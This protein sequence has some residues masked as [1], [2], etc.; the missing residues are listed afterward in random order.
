[1][2]Q[3][4]KVVVIHGPNLNL[5]GTREP[6]IYGTTTLAEINEMIQ[7]AA[8]SLGWDADCF[9]SNHEGELIDR[10]Q[11]AGAE[12]AAALIINGGAL[13]HYS[14]A[15]ADAIRAVAVPAVEVHLSNIHARETFREHSVTGAACEGVITG[16]G[17]QGYL[18]AFHHLAALHGGAVSQEK[19][20][21]RD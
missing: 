9:Q 4:P 15:L 3:P 2:N 10:V 11:A 18:A 5:L 14:H 7:R 20:A 6:A 16:L 21:G 19:G 8:G 1:M 17:P 13:T 12:G